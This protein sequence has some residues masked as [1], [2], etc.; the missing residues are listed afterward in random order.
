MHIF[1]LEFLFNDVNL[2]I[3]FELSIK[4]GKY[5]KNYSELINFFD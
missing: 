5:L 1:C 3:I 4:K 2:N